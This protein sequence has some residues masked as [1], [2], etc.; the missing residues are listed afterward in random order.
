MKDC[1]STKTNIEILF[2]ENPRL[3][4]KNT[5]QK[6]AKL[7]FLVTFNIIV[8][9]IFPKTFIEIHHVSQKVRIFTSSISAI[10]VNFLNFFLPVLATK[11]TNDVDIYKVISA[12]F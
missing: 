2:K 5:F 6:C 11:K 7:C 1:Y 3:N 4:P 8:N 9:Y 10:S 12:V